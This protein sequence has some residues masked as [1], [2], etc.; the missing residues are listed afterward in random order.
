MT[1]SSPLS[2]SIPSHSAVTQHPHA[3]RDQTSAS[4]NGSPGQWHS[5]RHLSVKALDAREETRG[6]MDKYGDSC[7][8]LRVESGAGTH[9][10]SFSDLPWKTPPPLPSSPP[11]ISFLQ[12]PLPVR[13]LSDSTPVAWHLGLSLRASSWHTLPQA[14]CTSVEN[15]PFESGTYFHKPQG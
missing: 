15:D 5:K 8:K 4:V 11:H 9:H 10:L 6:R 12:P 14:P 1:S 13:S 2:F 3:T 7:A